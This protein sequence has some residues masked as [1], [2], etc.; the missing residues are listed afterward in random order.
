MFAIPFAALVGYA[1]SQIKNV[2]G[3]NARDPIY[4][5]GSHLVPYLYILYIK[6]IGKKFGSIE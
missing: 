5:A 2:S 1:F 4:R 6:S 3:G